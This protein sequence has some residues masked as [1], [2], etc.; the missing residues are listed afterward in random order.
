MSCV[1]FFLAAVLNLTGVTGER[2]TAR[3]F[4]DANNVTVGDPLVLTVDF[5]G[6]ADFAE[7]H[8][9]L[10]SRVVNRTEW[11]LDDAS[12]KTDTLRT[13]RR[14][15]YRVR[16]MKPGVLWFPSLK[17]SYSGPTG[18][19]RRVV[20]N[21][22]PVHARPGRDVVVAGMSEAGG[23]KMPEPDPLVTDPPAGF[24]DEAAFAWRKACA[25]PTADAFAAFDCPEARMNEAACAIA[26]G[27]WKRALSVYARLEWRVGQ[28]PAVERGMRA[29][30]ARCYDNPDAELPVWR[31]VG[32]PVLRY[33]WQGRALIVFGSLALV[34]LL[35]WS[36]GRIIRAFAAVALAALLGLPSAARAETVET[37]TTNADGSIVRRRVTTGSNGGM[38]FS[39]TSSSSSG[40]MRPGAMMNFPGGDPFEMLDGFDPFGRRRARGN[41]PKPEIG[42]TLQADKPFVTVGESFNLVLTLDIPRYVSFS[43]GIQYALAEQDAFEQTARPQTLRAMPSANPTNVLQRILIPMRA[44]RPLRGLRYTV[45]GS[46]LY[47][48]E[49]SFFSRG[50]AWTSGPRASR[51]IVREPPEKGRPALYGGIVAEDLQFTERTDLRR[52]G[53]NDVVRIVYAL[54]W[55]GYVPD[56]FMPSGAAFAWDREDRGG[57]GHAEWQRYFVADGTP[58]TPTAEVVWYDPKAKCYRTRTAGGTILT[59]V[60]DARP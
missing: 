51:F 55:S 52:V 56:D 24:S 5:L 17:F 35:F 60:P 44:N 47:A 49:S 43:D 14:L 21:A 32:R 53:T 59:Y 27:D 28:N 13:A 36:L 34:T 22:I 42:V 31:Q 33:G 16:P 6:E 39:F 1:P 11:K 41:R 8:P 46:Y 50:T 12:A 26:A 54:D 23:E 9:P 15:T 2:L 30:Y 7:L 18:D 57:R 19:V 37:V 10:L 45:S 29:A 38:S 48:G 4:F 20:A 58:A 3:A 40:G 25:H